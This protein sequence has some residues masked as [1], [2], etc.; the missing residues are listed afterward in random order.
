MITVAMALF[1][2]ILMAMYNTGFQS[3]KAL[4]GMGS[5]E[6]AGW[7]GLVFHGL[8]FTVDKGSIIAAFLLGALYFVP[9]F[10]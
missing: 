4:E 6:V 9:V 3:L 5:L 10:V 2:C 8:G 1:P 7:R